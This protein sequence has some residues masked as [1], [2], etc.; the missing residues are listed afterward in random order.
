VSESILRSLGGRILCRSQEGRGTI[1][2]VMLP[3][4]LPGARDEPATARPAGGA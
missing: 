1:F 3:K 4:R 2:I